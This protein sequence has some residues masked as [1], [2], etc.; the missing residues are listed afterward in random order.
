MDERCTHRYEVI[1]RLA[2]G[3]LQ[4]LFGLPFITDQWV[5]DLAPFNLGPKR[6]KKYQL[7]T[8]FV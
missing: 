1:H 3:G 2:K 7:H 4:L 6:F 5:E 8:G